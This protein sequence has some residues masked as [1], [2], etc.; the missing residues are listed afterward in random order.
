MATEKV[1]DHQDAQ[2]PVPLYNYS[3]EFEAVRL[4]KMKG[5]GVR[6]GR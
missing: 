3:A 2:T 4:N 6:D 5:S 1:S